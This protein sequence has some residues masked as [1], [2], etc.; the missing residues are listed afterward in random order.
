VIEPQVPPLPRYVFSLVAVAAGGE[1]KSFRDRQL[2]ANNAALRHAIDYAGALPSIGADPCS[3]ATVKQWMDTDAPPS[4]LFLFTGKL[5]DGLDM[6]VRGRNK[7][8]PRVATD[9][10]TMFDHHALLALAQIILSAAGMR[11]ARDR[12][13]SEAFQLIA[14]KSPR[15]L[16]RLLIENYLG[17]I[18]HDYFD[19]VEIRAEFPRLPVDTENNL[20]VK[21]GRAIAAAIFESL[22]P[23][24]GPA[25]V[26]D[27]QE[28][29]QTMIGSI[30]LAERDL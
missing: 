5:L 11:S 10:A 3:S 17:N 1:N 15:S 22:P 18:L 28:A 19:A 24:D 21:Y 16:Q 29:L 27:I 30:W 14:R 2:I 6:R 12:D 7:R 26:H 23:G 4:D 9:A 8:L 25:P 20:R 13:A